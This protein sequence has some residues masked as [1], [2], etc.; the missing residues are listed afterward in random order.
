[1][2]APLKARREP[3]IANYKNKALFVVGGLRVRFV[4]TVEYY[5]LESNSWSSAPDLNFRRYGHCVCFLGDRLFVFGG[6]SGNELNSIEWLNVSTL[7]H[8]NGCSS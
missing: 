1:M 6:Q 8:Q 7:F 5:E 2:V 3:A 4:S